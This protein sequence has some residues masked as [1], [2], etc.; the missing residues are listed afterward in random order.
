VWATPSLG[1][2]PSAASV[3]AVW[4]VSVSKHG[5]RPSSKFLEFLWNLLHEVLIRHPASLTSLSSSVLAASSLV[6]L[7]AVV[8]N[9]DHDLGDLS[10]IF[11][12][13]KWM[14]VSFG[15]LTSLAVVKVLAHSALV[16][17]A[18]DWSCIAAVTDDVWMHLLRIGLEFLSGLAPVVGCRI[19][20]VI[21]H[22][23]LLSS[24]SSSFCDLAWLR[25]LVLEVALSFLVSLANIDVAHGLIDISLHHVLGLVLDRLLDQFFHGLP[26]LL[27]VFLAFVLL[28]AALVLLLFGNTNRFVLR[29]AGLSCLFVSFGVGALRGHLHIFIVL[30]RC[31]NVVL[32][33]LLFLFHGDVLELDACRVFLDSDQQFETAVRLCLCPLIGHSQ[34][35]IVLNSNLISV[36]VLVLDL[37][38]DVWRLAILAQVLF[39]ELSQGGEG[40]RGFPYF[41]YRMYH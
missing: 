29:L 3:M 16:T 8:D 5:E 13:Q 24:P 31:L 4:S 11:D 10:R 32:F 28:L 37:E 12:H 25:L 2:S 34:V 39:D 9:S 30:R 7:L 17:N 14:L 19:D 15:R 6:L 22:L 21:L 36:L 35:L 33:K 27:H 38:I 18:S 40:F 1:S 41:L 26:L 20:L 23:F